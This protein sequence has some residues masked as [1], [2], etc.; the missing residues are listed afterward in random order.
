M[1]ILYSREFLWIHEGISMKAS[2]AQGPLTTS[3]PYR[4][5]FFGV[6]K[7]EHPLKAFVGKKPSELPGG[8]GGTI[9]VGKI[10]W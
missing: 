4:N 6:Q 1:W 5:I 10:I 3:N 7:K 9:A 2:V 8:G